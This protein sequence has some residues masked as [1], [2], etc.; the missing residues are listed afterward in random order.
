M[1][2]VICCVYDSAVGQYL[3]PFFQR[4]KMEALRSFGTFANQEGHDFQRYSAD[5]TLFA[6]GEF[7]PDD[8]TIDHYQAPERLAVAIELIQQR[9]DAVQTELPLVA[10][11]KSAH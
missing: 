11:E 5:Y 4:S 2:L 3:T 10:E 7:N 8:G 1:N 6:L 9:P